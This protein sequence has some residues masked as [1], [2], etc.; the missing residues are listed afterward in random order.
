[1][2]AVALLAGITTPKAA[3]APVSVYTLDTD[4]SD[5]LGSVGTWLS[6]TTAAAALAA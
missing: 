3:A 4:L 1:M 6:S 5:S 2:L